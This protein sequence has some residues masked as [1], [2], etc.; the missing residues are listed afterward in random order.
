MDRLDRIVEHFYIKVANALA[1]VNID[2]LSVAQRCV[3]LTF[4]FAPLTPIVFIPLIILGQ[5]KSVGIASVLCC[6]SI[7]VTIFGY[8]LANLI[9][10]NL[11]QLKKPGV[12]C[13]TLP[14]YASALRMRMIHT[15]IGLGQ[16]LMGAILCIMSFTLYLTGYIPHTFVITIELLMSSSIFFAP[17]TLLFVVFALTTNKPNLTERKTQRYR[18]PYQAKMV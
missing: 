4:L 9:D 3:A 12:L 15:P 14:L 13:H 8:R 16:I 6:V 2:I 1:V 18:S 5:I 17:F 7:P 11:E 10:R